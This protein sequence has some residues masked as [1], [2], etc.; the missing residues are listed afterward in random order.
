MPLLNGK[1]LT[2]RNMREA[3]RMLYRSDAATQE[4]L[5]IQAEYRRELLRQVVAKRKEQ[6]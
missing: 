2:D 5:R 6:A 1:R 4:S 3:F